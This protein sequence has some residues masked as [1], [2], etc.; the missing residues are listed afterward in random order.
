MTDLAFI[1]LPEN[2]QLDR[3]L[4]EDGIILTYEKPD[5]SWEESWDRFINFVSFFMDDYTV[6]NGVWEG[7]SEVSFWVPLNSYNLRLAVTGAKQW[8]QDAILIN[9]PSKQD[10]LLLEKDGILKLP[11]M[12][13]IS[14]RQAA[15][16][17]GY[18]I[19]MDGDREIYLAC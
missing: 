8:D 6:L 19:F 3:V 10:A 1:V 13:E 14:A 17:Q 2:Q 12:K 15:E 4:N 18:S 5:L 11:V 9:R 16:L 7:V